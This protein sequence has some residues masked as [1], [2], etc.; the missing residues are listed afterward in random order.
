MMRL[1]RSTRF[2]A[3]SVLL[4]AALI[5]SL[6]A[7]TV[8]AEK[9]DTTAKQVGDVTVSMNVTPNPPKSGTTAELTI[10]VMRTGKPISSSEGAPHLKVDMPKMPMNLPEVPLR[11]A[12]EGRWKADVKFPMAG[13]WAATVS[14]PPKQDTVTFQ[15]DVGP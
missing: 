14:V 6:A 11:P 8:Q 9:L 13:G 12:G 3:G 2:V 15:F 7:C 10:A 1:Q 4:P 5:I